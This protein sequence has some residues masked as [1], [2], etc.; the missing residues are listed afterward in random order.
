MK[1]ED[2]AL[3]GVRLV[4]L[5]GPRNMRSRDM[6]GFLP[7]AQSLSQKADDYILVC[8]FLFPDFLAM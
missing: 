3:G 7:R 6:H 5:S 1:Y 4:S 8:L 2:G